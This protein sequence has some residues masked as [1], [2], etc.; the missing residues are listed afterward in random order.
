M[1]S[2][3]LAFCSNN[4][5]WSSLLSPTRPLHSARSLGLALPSTC[6]QARKQAQQ[7]GQGHLC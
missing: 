5:F 7:L 2:I 4:A 3:L 6:K 1:S